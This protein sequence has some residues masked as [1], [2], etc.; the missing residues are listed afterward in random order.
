MRNSV[1]IEATD[2][3]MWWQSFKLGDATAFRQLYEAFMPQLYSYGK[4]FASD[5]VL[6]EDTIQDL[7]C[8]LWADRTRLGDPVSVKNY[9][10]KAFRT[11]LYKKLRKKHQVVQAPESLQFHFEFTM[12]VDEVII[13]KEQLEGIKKDIDRALYRLTDRQR[14]II[15]YR[16]YLNLEFHEIAELMEMQTRATYKLTARALEMLRTAMDPAAFIFFILARG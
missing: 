15:Y 4:K 5:A 3:Q 16:F 6:I 2:V 14:E 7:F 8:T 11:T 12:P 9:L 1:S 10:L 13:E